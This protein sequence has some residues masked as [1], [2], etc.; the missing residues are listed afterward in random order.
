LVGL[1][2]V[3][4]GA[5]DTPAATQGATIDS[6]STSPAT[7]SST[8][9]PDDTGATTA[10]TIGA[11][12]TITDELSA[13]LTETFN[14]CFDRAS[15]PPPPITGATWTI[16]DVPGVNPYLVKHLAAGGGRKWVELYL[17]PADASLFLAEP[18]TVAVGDRSVLLAEEEE[19][20]I[21]GAEFRTDDP[22]C[23]L[24][25]ARALGLSDSEI[26]STILGVVLS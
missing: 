17:L 2:A 7:T 18:R 4:L 9:R 20:G 15:L 22:E 24:L 5:C 16:S 11:T 12:T 13:R 25:A 3:M 10:V 21:V 23:P 1:V 26:V 8:S 6:N 14:L 19:L